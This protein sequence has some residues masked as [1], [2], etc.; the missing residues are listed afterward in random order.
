MQSST[1]NRSFK[2]A[3][4]AKDASKAKITDLELCGAIAQV[5]LGQ[6]DDLGGGVFKKRLHSNQHR[7][8]IL[9]KGGTFWIYEYL[10]A[11][12]DRD[13]IEHDEL[14]AFRLLAKSYAGLTGHQL[15]QLLINKDLLEI[16]HDEKADVQK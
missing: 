9:A 16:C 7:S 14:A 6:V 15:G 2:T 1:S 13:N 8:I 3:K 11:K 10:F 5:L 12:K 4:F